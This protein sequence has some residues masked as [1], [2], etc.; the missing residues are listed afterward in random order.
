MG[1]GV[2]LLGG[3]L[4][5]LGVLLGIRERLRIGDGSDL[6]SP[7]AKVGVEEGKSDESPEYDRQH[8]DRKS[9]V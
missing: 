9:V 6:G 8:Q 4:S 5:R 7:I 2:G 3:G 1:F